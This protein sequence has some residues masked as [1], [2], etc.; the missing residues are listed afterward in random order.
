MKNKR[1]LAIARKNILNVNML[2]SK[3]PDMLLRDKWPSYFRKSKKY[4]VWDLDGNKYYDMFFG[5]GQSN[6]GYANDLVDKK[7]IKEIKLGNM[8]S[9]NSPYEVD[10]STE[11][12]NI[13]KWSNFVKFAKSG[14]EANAIAVIIARSNTKKK[15]IAICGYHGWHD[16]YISSNLASK[17]NLNNHLFKN[18]EPHGIHPNLKNTTFTFKYNDFDSLKYLVDKK[19][20]GI[21]KMEVQRFEKPKNN[22]LKKIKDLCLKKKLILIFDECTTGFRECYGGLHLKYNIKPDIVTY[23]KA[24]G[25]GY[26]ITA[27]LCSKKLKQKAEKCFI[28]STFWTEKS[29]SVAALETLKIMKKEKP[30]VQITRA[31]KKIKKFWLEVSKEFNIPIKVT[32][33]DS[34]P[35]FYFKL[36]NSEKVKKFFVAEMLKRKIL[37]T[38]LIY[39]SQVHNSVI[40]KKYFKS[41]KEVFK[42][43]SK[44]L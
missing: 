2:L 31:G 36:K 21:V 42:K 32:G 27:V 30:W 33:L 5:V 37:A 26:P 6:L 14:G 8:C 19:R 15:N 25:N 41:F 23:G 7:V 11:L 16:W 24:L 9:L 17:K 35:V 10:L 34:I 18:L 13:H 1:K 4:N 3:N 38:N 12:I 43:I 39:V 44:D 29:G 22:F 20:I 40:L 28:S